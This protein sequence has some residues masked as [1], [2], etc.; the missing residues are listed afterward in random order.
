MPSLRMAI[1]HVDDAQADAVDREVSR[2]L[3]HD[4]II[5]DF[6]EAIEAAILSEGRNPLSAMRSLLNDAPLLDDY[7]LSCWANVGQPGDHLLAYFVRKLY[8]QAHLAEPA[9]RRSLLT[10]PRLGALPLALR[11]A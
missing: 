6:C 9:L 8:G 5:S 7:D 11:R 2:R 3:N 10:N 1:P 4:H